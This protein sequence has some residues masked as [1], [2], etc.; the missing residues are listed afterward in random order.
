LPLRQR[1]GRRW[2]RSGSGVAEER[3][4]EGGAEERHDCSFGK[5]TGRRRGGGAVDEQTF[6]AQS[7]PAKSGAKAAT[8]PLQVSLPPTFSSAPPRC[9]HPRPSLL[10]ISGSLLL[11]TAW[12]PL[13]LSP[14]AAVLL[15]CEFRSLNFDSR[16][17]PLPQRE[18][19]SFSHSTPST[20]TVRRTDLGNGVGKSRA[21]STSSDEIQICLRRV[22][23]FDDT[24]PCGSNIHTTENLSWCHSSGFS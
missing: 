10:L 22:T 17:R 9:S 13:P 19:P 2:R 4:A 18:P 3:G 1:P 11:D 6:S 7:W 12:R 8:D 15:R 23:S 21:R 14:L 24:P 16:G 20:E 5:G